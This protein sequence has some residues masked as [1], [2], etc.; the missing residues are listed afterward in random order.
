[1]TYEIHYS[2]AADRDLSKLPIE[3]SRNIVQSIHKIRD[4]PFSHITKM[5]DRDNPPQYR[6]RVGDYRVIMILDK[7][8]R[9]LLV[10]GAGHRSTIYKRYGV[11]G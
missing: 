1:M 7:T 11:K 4:D 5:K 9:V 2:K 6:L 10:D 8:K 3:I